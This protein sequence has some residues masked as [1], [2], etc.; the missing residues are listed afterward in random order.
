M[1]DSPRLG[2]S[3]CRVTQIQLTAANG[4]VGMTRYRSGLS[5]GRWER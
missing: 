2:T 3:G 4:V 5:T 1:V